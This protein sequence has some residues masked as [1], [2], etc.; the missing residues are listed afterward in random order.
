MGTQGWPPGLVGHTK[1]CLRRD[2]LVP[3]NNSL[4]V[5][6]L[7]LPLLSS[8]VAGSGS[9][10]Q[11]PKTPW[12]GKTRVLNAGLS[13]ICDSYPVPPGALARREERALRI[14]AMRSSQYLS[15]GRKSPTAGTAGGQGRG[16][17]SWKGPPG[18]IAP[19]CSTQMRE[20]RPRTVK[21]FPKMTELEPES[22]PSVSW[23][24]VL[25][26]VRVV[27]APYAVQVSSGPGVPL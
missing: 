16:Q 12:E 7:W 6:H 5:S 19:K 14:Q 27:C 13:G 21:R 25:C 23:V 15:C 4:G 2:F 9:W 10:S 1:R 24:C 22:R 17:E 8:W 26:I 3:L 18:F 20:P 11:G